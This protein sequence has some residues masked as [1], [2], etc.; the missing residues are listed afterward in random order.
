MSIDL[1]KLKQ[2]SANARD[3]VNK[4]QAEQIARLLD[5]ND[6]AIIVGKLRQQ[7]VPE[8]E[9]ERLRTEIMTADNR[10]E[11]IIQ[12]CCQCTILAKALKVLL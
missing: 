1:S 2:A 5:V 10:N 3:E 9:I 6:L 12:V 4:E 8:E 11:T 7:A